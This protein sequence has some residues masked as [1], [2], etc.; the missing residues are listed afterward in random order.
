[1]FQGGNNGAVV[2]PYNSA[3]SS[4][5]Y[6]INTHP[7][8]GP[9]A[10]PTMPLNETPL[11]EDEYL[12]IKNWIETGAADI[13]GNIPFATDASTRQKIYLTM[14]GCDMVA[15]IDAQTKVVMRYIEVGKTPAIE[16]PHCVRVSSDGRF[17]YVSFLGGDYIQKINTET[18][19]VVDELQVGIGSWNVFLLSP[20][21]KKMLLSD[22]RP[23]PNGRLLLINTETMEVITEF[24]GLFHYPHGIASDASFN[25]FYITAQYGNTVY[26]LTLS[27]GTLKQVSIDGATPVTIAGIRDPHEVLMTPDGSKYFLTCEHSNEVRIM[28]AHADTLIRTIPVG[29]K[30]QEMA[31]SSSRPYIFVTC[32]EDNSTSAML[33]GSVYAINHRSEVV[34]IY[35]GAGFNDSK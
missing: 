8:Y 16:N 7:E 35:L 15:V 13:N 26:K 30:P 9:V 4:L 10:S 33:K 29:I 2:I 31:L 20:D 21:G 6:F 18:D 1:M 11:T 12:L 34:I 22:W 24:T 23:Q 19:A 32:M 28:D 3:N 25:T 17:A 14:Q 5:L 27:S